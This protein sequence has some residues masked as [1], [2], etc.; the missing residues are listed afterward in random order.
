MHLYI[1][2][3]V[4]ETDQ[5][6]TCFGQAT[7]KTTYIWRFG[8]SAYIPYLTIS[9]SSSTTLEDYLCRPQKRYNRMLY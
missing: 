2:F 8:E 9:Y 3:E 7:L 5:Y 6:H 1:F 4:H